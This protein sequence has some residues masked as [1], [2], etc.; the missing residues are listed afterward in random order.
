MALK[1]ETI[2]FGPTI[3][4]LERAMPIGFREAEGGLQVLACPTAINL[5]NRSYARAYS[6]LSNFE[7]EDIHIN[8]VVNEIHEATHIDVPNVSIEELGRDTLAGFYLA[9]FWKAY[10]DARDYDIYHHMHL[11]FRGANPAAIAG[12]RDNTPFLVGP[13][14]AGHDVPPNEVKTILRR[15]VSL[16]LPEW[17]IEATYNA[18]KPLKDSIINPA[19]EYA[20][21]KTLQAADRIVAVH[22]DA[23]EQFAQYTDPEKIEVIPY[24]VDLEK[25]TFEGG[26]TEP[27]IVTVGNLIHRKGHR[28]LLRAMPKILDK[29]PTAHLHIVGT[30]YLETDLQNLAKELSVADSTTFHGFVPDDELLS[31]LH[32]ARVFVHPS[33]SEGFSHV[34]LEA[35][36]TG[37]PVV[38]TNVSGAHELT[39]HGEDGFVVPRCS[40]SELAEATL[41][42]LLDERRAREMGRR[43]REHVE[44]DHDY[45]KIGKRYLEIYRELAAGKET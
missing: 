16:T 40:S 25:F 5:W 8:A 41:Q 35:M 4:L 45:E 38:G 26:E 23:K 34:R 32:S 14:E 21:A 33:S 42:L 37:T 19:R 24:G 15:Q 43:A 44:Q 28:Y 22:S 3:F 29:V 10:Q 18:L 7:A 13:A 2:F 1:A 27:Q 36:A 11:G 31:L 20:F 6:L 12:L 30:G 9:A 39:N 17:A